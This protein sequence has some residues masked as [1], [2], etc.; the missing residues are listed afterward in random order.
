MDSYYVFLA[1]FATIL[2]AISVVYSK[3]VTSH[4]KN[5]INFLSLQTIIYFVMITAIYLIMII[6]GEDINKNLTFINLFY[7]LA[8]SIFVFIGLMTY[9]IGLQHGNASV[10]GVIMSTRVIISITLV[11]IFVNEPYPL[12]SY[13]WVIF[14]VFGAIMVSWQ[15]GISLKESLFSKES[16]SSWFFLTIFFWAITSLFIRL[17]NNEI[18]F[19]TYLLLRYFVQL[20]LVIFLYRILNRNFGNN[21]PLKFGSQLKFP[22][23]LV[24]FN[25]IILMISDFGF[26]IAVGENMIAT[27]TIVALG[28]LLVFLLTLLI[29]L[30]NDLRRRLDEPLDKQTLFVRFLGV[31]LATVGV[32]GF[33]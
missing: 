12:E 30:N 29:S 27:E 9:Y 16:G 6:L 8:S 28:G 1:F 23:F 2:L 24:M 26:V 33:L 4:L 18:H 15:K 32:L 21:E 20:I 3:F 13:F 22:I 25:A 11:W 14:V 31:I 7:V 17:L 5:P 10:G 19:I